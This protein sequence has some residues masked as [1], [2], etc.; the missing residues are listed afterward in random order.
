[1]SNYARK[2]EVL[3]RKAPPPKEDSR[4]AMKKADEAAMMKAKKEN[5]QENEK[6]VRGR[7]KAMVRG[8]RKHLKKEN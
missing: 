6:S 1:M 2:H 7:S 3:T 5:E 4:Q 8:A